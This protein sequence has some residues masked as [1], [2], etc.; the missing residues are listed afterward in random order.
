MNDEYKACKYCAHSKAIKYNTDFLCKYK[1]V[2]GANFICKKYKFN[3]LAV[4]GRRRKLDFS[5]FTA[6]D[7]SID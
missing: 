1:G 6:E 5:K 7:F 4:E 2:V 3:P